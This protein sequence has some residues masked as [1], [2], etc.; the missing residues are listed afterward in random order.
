M[1]VALWITTPINLIGF[2]AFSPLSGVPMSAAGLPDEIHPLFRWALAEFI[3]L[4]GL[5]YGWCAWRKQAP[6][7]F[8][9]LGAAGKLAF[10]ATIAS[11]WAAGAVPFQAVTSAS[12]DLFLGA[13]FAVWVL[14]AR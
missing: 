8:I 1:V 9:A 6:R 10:F 2:F 7:M 11:Y 14:R 5:G 4:F 3:G 12:P 13:A